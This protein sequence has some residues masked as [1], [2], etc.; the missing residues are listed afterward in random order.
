[1]SVAWAVGVWANNSWVGMNGGPPNAWRGATTPVPTPTTTTTTQ[2]TG[3]RHA[4]P[5]V[6][7]L[8]DLSPE[9]RQSTADFLKAQLGLDE[10]YAQSEGA[11]E[12]ATRTFR[13]G[14]KTRADRERERLAEL[15]MRNA[16]IE[17]QDEIRMVR[18]NNIL[19]LI[20]MANQ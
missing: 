8:S 13:A 16:E 7:R 9:S 1:M 18:N 17:S 12:Q 6:I 15:A 4:R 10:K 14:R 2:E 20:M 3:V 19:L 11:A 5:P